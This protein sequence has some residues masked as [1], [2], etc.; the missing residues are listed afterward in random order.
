LAVCAR[1]S[2]PAGAD[3]GDRAFFDS[4]RVGQRGAGVRRVPLD[5]AL[6][7]RQRV[8]GDVE[9]DRLLLERE[10]LLLGPLLRAFDPLL[11]RR[12]GRLRAAAEEPELT[13]FTVFLRP[14][15]LLQRALD[16]VEQ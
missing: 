1:P 16:G 6:V 11:G 4:F 9:A 12:V 7:P 8:A 13:G 3:A 10:P 14:D 15:A 2:A 5:V